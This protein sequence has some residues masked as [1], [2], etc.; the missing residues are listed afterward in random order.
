[1][2]TQFEIILNIYIYKERESHDSTTICIDK[3][4]LKYIYTHHHIYKKNNNKFFFLKRLVDVLK[5]R[6]LQYLSSFYVGKNK[7]KYIYI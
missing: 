2:C 6:C 3:R 4:H 5:T 7:Y 1:M